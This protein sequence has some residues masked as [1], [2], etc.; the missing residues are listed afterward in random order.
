VDILSVADAQG[1]TRSA[2]S[3][4]TRARQACGNRHDPVSTRRNSTYFVDAFFIGDDLESSLAL[5]VG[6]ARHQNDGN[7]RSGLAAHRYAAFDRACSLF[8][9]LRLRGEIYRQGED[10]N[11]R[12][13]CKVHKTSTD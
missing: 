5:I 8:L 7:A 2:V 13:D 12:L 10:Q 4:S 6:F 11:G 1:L 3:I 9:L